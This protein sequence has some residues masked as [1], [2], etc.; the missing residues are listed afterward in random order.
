M[1]WE[2]DHYP[3]EAQWH[4]LKNTIKVHS[5]NLML[6]KD[7]PLDRTKE[8]LTALGFTVIVF[9]QASNKMKQADWLAT[10]NSN[11]ES[12]KQAIK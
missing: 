7:E 8:H 4:S 12:L 5:A 10:M 3:S 11:T 2:P 9:S 6:W 1:Q